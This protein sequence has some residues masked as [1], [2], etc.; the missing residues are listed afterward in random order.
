MDRQFA[1]LLGIEVGEPKRTFVKSIPLGRIE[2]PEDV[3][4]TA[5]FLASADAD[6]MTQQTLNAD[7]GNWPS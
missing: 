2:Q 1:S 4:G 6:Y 7:G 5:I 3:T